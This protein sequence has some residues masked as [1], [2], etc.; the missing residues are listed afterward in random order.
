VRAWIAGLGGRLGFPAVGAHRRFVAALAID[1]VGS[2]VWQPVSILYFLAQTDLSLVEVGL[3]V[4]IGSFVALPLVPLTGQLV[5]TFGAKRLLQTGNVLQA[6]GF[7]AYPLAHSLGT[8]TAVLV[9]STA[10]RT[11]FWGSYGPLVAGITR[12][13]ERETWF[14]FLHAMRNAGF[15]IGGLVA[16][17][18][19]SIG[20]DAAYTTVVVANAASYVLAWL[21]MRTVPAGGRATAGPAAPLGGWGVVA[22]D[23]GYRWLVVNNLGNAMAGMALTITMPVYF[24]T[25]LGLPGWTPG[26]VFVINTVMIGVGQGLV[27]RR[28]TGVVRTHVILAAVAFTAVGYAAMWLAAPLP[29]AAA[30]VV[31]LAGAVVFTL[32]EMSG[33]PVISALAAESPPA[34]LRGRYMAVVQLS[35]SVASTVAP[36]LFTAMLDAGTAVTW[37]GLLVLL[38]LWALTC[39]P[40]HRRLPLASRP[41]TNAPPGG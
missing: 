3:A 23:R 13:G 9:V 36:L 19:V 1:A 25:L 32:G 37:G 30:V 4:S 35:W 27:V 33:S 14:G 29:V 41:V 17:A 31:V 2:G 5:D 8:V 39:V 24:V 28:M 21:L 11:F 22:R 15:G 26:A 6:V 7:A 10:G 16:A 40:L 12:E 34:E 20:S 38:G 18:A